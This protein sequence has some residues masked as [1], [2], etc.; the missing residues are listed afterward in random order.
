M[1]SEERDLEPRMSLDKLGMRRGWTPMGWG[2]GRQDPK[3]KNEQT[4]PWTGEKLRT[5]LSNEELR[6]RPSV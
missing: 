4:T 2:R 6:R 1:S 5:P 3:S